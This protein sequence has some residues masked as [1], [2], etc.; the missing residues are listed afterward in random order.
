MWRT[1]LSVCLLRM[2]LDSNYTIN[3]RSVCHLRHLQLYKQFSRV[4]GLRS[5]ISD[6]T[7]LQCHYHHNQS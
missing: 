5:K 6:S 1:I 4:Y 7:Y 3:I 2:S